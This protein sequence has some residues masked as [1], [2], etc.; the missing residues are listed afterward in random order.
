VTFGRAQREIERVA[1]DE[2]DV[3]VLGV[4]AARGLDRLFFGST[5]QHVLRAGI[6]PVL[7]VRHAPVA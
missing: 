6:C 3:V 7:L 2:A 1:R 4:S 5:A